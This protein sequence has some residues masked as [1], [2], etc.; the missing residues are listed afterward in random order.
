MDL[1][2]DEV[3]ANKAALETMKMNEDEYAAYVAD[4]CENQAKNM[5]YAAEAGANAQVDSLK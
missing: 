1:G 2:M 4:A 3:N 5:S